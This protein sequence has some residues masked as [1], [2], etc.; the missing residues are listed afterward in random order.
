MGLAKDKYGIRENKIFLREK[1]PFR[2]KG[3]LINNYIFRPSEIN[4]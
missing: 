1:W 3:I 4:K 2:D